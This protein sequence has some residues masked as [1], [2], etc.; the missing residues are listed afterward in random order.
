MDFTQHWHWPQWVLLVMILLQVIIQTKRHGQPKLEEVGPRKGEVELY[1]GF[2][3]IVR[4]AILIA[5][6]ICGGFFA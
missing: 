5:I 4:A 6:L 3:A 1:N 2:N